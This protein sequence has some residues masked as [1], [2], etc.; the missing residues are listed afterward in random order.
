MQEELNNFNHNEVS[1]LVERP[2]QNIT[3]TKWVFCNKQDKHGVVIRNKS[4][5]V[6]KCYSQVESLDFDETFASVVRLESIRM[7]LA[8]ATQH[9]FKLYQMDIKSV[10]LNGIIKEDVYVEQPPDFESEGYS[11]HVYKLHKT[12]YEL[13]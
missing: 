13:K 1:S 7:L 4:R 10:F 5:F 3:G 9:G 2:M 11:N 6:A 8:Y 12:L